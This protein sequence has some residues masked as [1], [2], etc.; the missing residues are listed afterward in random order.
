MIDPVWHTASLVHLRRMLAYAKGSLDHDASRNMVFGFRQ[1][2]EL[3]LPWGM[4]DGDAVVR[5]TLA[6]PPSVQ[7]GKRGL[8]SVVVFAEAVR[9]GGRLNP[10]H[11]PGDGKP[12][13]QPRG[14]PS[15]TTSI[16]DYLREQ[17]DG[18]PLIPVGDGS[19]R[20]VLPSFPSTLDS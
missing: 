11:Y 7:T 9:F 4:D 10:P 18:S 20:F 12:I 5:L 8:L 1:Q 3:T 17:T 19:L 15:L 14:V 2:L 6:P 16:A 13:T